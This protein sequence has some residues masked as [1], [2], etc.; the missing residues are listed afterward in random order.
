MVGGM[1]L[2]VYKYPVPLEDEF[3]LDLP[4]AAKILTFQT[5]SNVPCVWALVDPDARPAERQFRLAGTGHP[6]NEAE[7]DL[8]YVGTVQLHGGALVF[9]LF[10]VLS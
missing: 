9:H 2:T 6:I 3:T 7:R 1:A 5:Q 10:E 4:M 8:V